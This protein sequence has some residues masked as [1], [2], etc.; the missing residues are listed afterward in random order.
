M[1]DAA[2]APFRRYKY[3][4][5]SCWWMFV[6][7]AFPFPQFSFFAANWRGAERNATKSLFWVPWIQ[8]NDSQQSSCSVEYGSTKCPQLT[9]WQSILFTGICI[10][11]G[12]REHQLG[13][14]HLGCCFFDPAARY[15]RSMAGAL[16]RG[17][18]TLELLKEL[19]WHS[20]NEIIISYKYYCLILKPFCWKWQ[21]SLAVPLFFFL[22]ALPTS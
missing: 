6:G 16:V 4:L 1:G 3:N 20:E 9:Y 21:C 8:V 15:C 22:R 2:C 11:H 5:S 14:S 13:G 18:P 12:W 19:P 10:C 7:H 17:A